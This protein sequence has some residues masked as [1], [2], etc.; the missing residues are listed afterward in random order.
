TELSL[1][2]LSTLG[3]T[4]LD[5]E[6][7]MTFSAHPHRVE[8]RRAAYNFG[9]RYGRVTELDLFELPDGGRVRRIGSLP[10]P[11]PVLLHDFVAT[12]NHL[13]FFVAPVRL[14][15]IRAMLGMGSFSDNLAWSRSEGT[16]V[17][18][19]PLDD[20][21]RPVRFDVDAFFQWHF[22]NAFERGGELVVDLVR[23]QDFET[24]RWLGEV[25]S[26]E[27]SS[28]ASGEYHRAIVDPRRR[29]L[30]LEK[31]WDAS[32]E[33]PRVSPL[34]EGKPHRVA[35]VASHLPDGRRGM[36]QRI[37]RLDVE[38]GHAVHASLPAGHFPSEPVFVP[39][40]DARAEDE[41]WLL[42]LVYDAGAHASHVAILEADA[43]EKGPIARA[44]FDHH[45]PFTFHGGWLPSRR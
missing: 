30:R 2:D 6:V 33:F 12:P 32:C 20:P 26:G 22:A 1:D 36:Y 10:L 14:R 9:M 5:G 25:A 21:S 34:V 37:T 4:D 15:A 19:V 42:S 43:L 13:A 3:Q 29:T 27:T 7:R 39:R 16:E 44:S 11:A 23:Y 38:S 45:L 18:V 8:E 41:G 40:P 31:R 17:I 28:D 24:N 35:Y